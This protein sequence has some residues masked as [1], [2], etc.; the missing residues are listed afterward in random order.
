MHQVSWTALTFFILACRFHSL[1]A[2]QLVFQGLPYPN[3]SVL[4][5]N[6]VGDYSTSRYILCTTNRSPCCST[7]PNRFGQWRY[8]DGSMVPKNADDEDFYRGRGDNQAIY[9]NRRNNA[10]S[11]TGSFCCEL[12]DNSDVHHTLCLTLGTN[13]VTRYTFYVPF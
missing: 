7:P 9:L 12:P 1:V 5:L 11:P 8:P 3:N 6:D 2:V 10:Q 13:T 4:S